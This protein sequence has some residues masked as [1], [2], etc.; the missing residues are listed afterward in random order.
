MVEE[1]QP[2]GRLAEYRDAELSWVLLERLSVQFGC[3]GEGVA[4]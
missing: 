4:G 1:A 3:R 2:F